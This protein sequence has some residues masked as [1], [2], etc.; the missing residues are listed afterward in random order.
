MSVVQNREVTIVRFL[1]VKNVHAKSNGAFRAVHCMDV[2]RILEGP[3][4]EVPL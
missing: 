3:L 1:E 4:R 2:V